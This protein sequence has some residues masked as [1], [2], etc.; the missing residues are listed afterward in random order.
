MDEELVHIQPPEQSNE[1][2]RL[3][4]LE[5]IEPPIFSME[6]T[7]KEANVQTSISNFPHFSS[8][9]GA[10]KRGMMDVSYE[11]AQPELPLTNSESERKKVDHGQIYKANSMKGKMKNEGMS[12]INT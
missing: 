4:E 3:N 10:P 1:M 5:M 11:V 9:S 2:G 12:E 6:P 7:M 8:G